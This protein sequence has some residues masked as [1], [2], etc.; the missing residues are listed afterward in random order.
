MKMGTT[1]DQ[2]ASPPLG[3]SCEKIGRASFL[4][5]HRPSKSLPDEARREPRPPNL[6]RFL[7]SSQL[8]DCKG[9]L[10]QTARTHP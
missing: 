7:I 3:G 10:F 9:G 5:S 4:A 6:P 1:K 2:N 8:Q